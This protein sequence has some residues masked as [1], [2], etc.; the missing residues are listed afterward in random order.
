MSRLAA[1]TPL[2]VLGLALATLAL[3]LTVAPAF[4]ADI[5]T[6]GAPAVPAGRVVDDDLYLF[7][8]SP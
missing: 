6:G 1:R 3:S 4:A 7:G 8:V 2:K 5:E